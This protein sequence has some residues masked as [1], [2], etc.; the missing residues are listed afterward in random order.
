[1]MGAQGPAESLL[2]ADLPSH[3]A[4]LASLSKQAGKSLPPL[5]SEFRTKVTL[6]GPSF[7][8]PR[9]SPLK[10]LFAIPTGLRASSGFTTL[11]AGSKLVSSLPSR[12]DPK[13]VPILRPDIPEG[14]ASAVS[15]SEVHHTFGIPWS[16][17]QFVK[18]ACKAQHPKTL[19][20]ALPEQMKCA[21]GKRIKQG[22][23]TTARHR[24]EVLRKW[25]LRA[26]DLRE[27]GPDPCICEAVAP[28]LQGKCMRL[29]KEL[30]EAS[31]YG[32]HA[33]PQDIGKGFD[34]VGQIPA[35][36]VLPK[37]ATFASLDVA[38]VREVAKENQASTIAATAD[39]SRSAEDEQIAQEVY[40]L[41]MQEVDQGWVRGPIPV[42]E[43]PPSSILTRR[44]GVVQS[45]FDSEK[46]SIKKVR[47]IDD[48]TASLA[49]LTSFSEETIAPHGVDIILAGLVYRAKLA[50]L[51][52]S[53]ERLVAK[54]VDLRKA[55]KQLPL[56]EAARSD[57]FLSVWCPSE[58]TVHIFQ[59]LVMPFGSRSSVQGFYRSS[60][61][62][63]HIGAVLLDLHWSLFYDDYV[64]V[65]SESESAHLSMVVDSFFE[66]VQWQTSK[67]KETP[68]N[69]VARALGV[70][71]SLADSRAGIF[72]VCNTASRKAELAA[73]ITS[74]IS[75]GGTT[76]KAFESLRGRLLFAENQVFG[77][78]ACQHM[79]ALSAACRNQ[80]FVSI[81]D[82]LRAALVYLR[83]RIV[84]GDA[85]V[86]SAA[87]RNCMHLYTD[88]SFE[89]GRGGL[90]AV[91][92]NS[93]GL[94]LRWFAETLDQEMISSLNVEGK[95]GFIY[96]LEALAAVRGVLDLC[97]KLVHTDLVLFLDNDAALRA[98]IK[99]NSSSPVLQA[100]LLRLNEFEMAHDV[101]I[102]FERIAS[103]SNPADAPSRDDT[104]HLPPSFR[105]RPCLRDLLNA[106]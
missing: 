7:L 80:G 92:Y 52:G 1:M 70:E 61:C 72:S 63:W 37:K 59:S 3:K 81:S 6:C 83:D 51:A 41:T 71:I 14:E 17:E 9:D 19:A 36:N 47:P 23:A 102:W 43:L 66:L 78:L 53:C 22:P 30:I 95:K 38:D 42:D 105:V 79:R 24:T 35:S 39:A 100:L 50:K 103:A 84:L 82:D 57:A 58:K 45:S 68:F 26:K 69:A 11:P 77:R 98:L 5:V 48:F 27:L 62:L 97:T 16:P 74:I 10:Q 90:G 4:A 54:T 29:L 15:S 87:H 94:L 12:G 93:D 67:D 25:F 89:N 20:K 32:D 101:N 31:G 18:F 104:S 28:L 75:D 96:E 60:H 13:V 86:V 85:R 56:S 44:F 8:M 64:V 49:N 76:A 65:A 99:S 46:G 73:N 106:P 91:L 34:I 21:I 40:S 55:Y 88:A 33:L 2:L